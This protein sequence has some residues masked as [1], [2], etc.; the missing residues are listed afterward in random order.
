MCQ[1]IKVKG[2]LCVN[3]DGY[4][5]VNVYKLSQTQSLDLSVFSHPCLYAGQ[6]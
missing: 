1:R 6:F 5:I 4:T 2:Y 3:V